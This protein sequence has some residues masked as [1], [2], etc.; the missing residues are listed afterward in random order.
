[1][2]Q[3]INY[4]NISIRNCFNYSSYVELILR[5]TYIN[6][7][8]LFVYIF[9]FLVPETISFFEVTDIGG[10][11]IRIAWIIPP[12]SGLPLQNFRLLVGP[13]RNSRQVIGKFKLPPQTP[14]P[15]SRHDYTET[16]TVWD[17][18]LYLYDQP[19]YENIFALSMYTD[20][21]LEGVLNPLL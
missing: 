13:D 19:Y 12:S 15:P 1:M 4:D 18:N 8:N 6:F 10:G 7:W 21:G 3:N 11:E 2:L 16:F 20:I 17:K 14:L 5:Q 9:S